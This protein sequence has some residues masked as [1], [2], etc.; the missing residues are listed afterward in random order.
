M[1]VINL[2]QWRRCISLADLGG[3]VPGAC[4]PL[5]DPILSFSHTFSPKS[6]HVR[7]PHPPNGSMPPYGK[8]WICHCIWCDSV[9]FSAHLHFSVGVQYP[10]RQC[11]LYLFCIKVI[12]QSVTQFHQLHLIA[13]V[14]LQNKAQREYDWAILMQALLH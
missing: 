13:I 5:R 3:G 6:A 14:T 2:V 11:P 10:T 4:H 1:T 7:G 8:S 9:K 12:R